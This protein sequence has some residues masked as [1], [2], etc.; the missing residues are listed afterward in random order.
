MLRAMANCWH[1]PEAADPHLFLKWKPEAGEKPTGGG[2]T[3]GP[4]VLGG[5]L[6]FTVCLLYPQALRSGGRPQPAVRKAL[7]P[8]PP[9]VSQHPAIQCQAH[10]KWPIKPTA[11]P[12]RQ[13]PT[14]WPR[15]GQGVRLGPAAQGRAWEMPGSWGL[16]SQRPGGQSHSRPHLSLLEHRPGRNRDPRAAARMEHLLFPSLASDHLSVKWAS[17]LPSL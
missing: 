12:R 16:G 14:P 11:L 1:R 8:F 10:S 13:I 2:L 4:G 15:G 9:V 6:V 5:N 7:D 3:L 17:V